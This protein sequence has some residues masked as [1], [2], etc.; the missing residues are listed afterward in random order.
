MAQPGLLQPTAQQM[1]QTLQERQKQKFLE[2][3]KAIATEKLSP[4]VVP[5]AFKYLKEFEL[6]WNDDKKGYNPYMEKPVEPTFKSDWLTS[7]LTGSVIERGSLSGN[8][9]GAISTDKILDSISDLA[10]ITSTSAA[11]TT[12]SNGE[13]AVLTFTLEDNAFPNRVMLAVAH[14]T[15][16]HG[17]VAGANI[18]P[19]GSSVTPTAWLWA[20]RADWNSNNNRRS[21]WVDYIRNVSAGA[22]QSV[23]WRLNYRYLGRDA[24]ES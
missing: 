11:S 4:N 22:S 5:D 7:D 12:L 20:N 24:G 16:F 15:P 18:I 14:I 2:E 23:L 17:S 8:Q 3:M 9:I 19:Y 21:T 1:E 6:S 13:Q 10:K